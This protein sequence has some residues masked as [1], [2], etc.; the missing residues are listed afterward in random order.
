M[1]YM[2]K[3]GYDKKLLEQRAKQDPRYAKK[4]RTCLR[5]RNV[6]MSNWAGHRWCHACRASLEGTRDI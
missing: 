3:P 6:F 5:C 4:E 1:A 2:V